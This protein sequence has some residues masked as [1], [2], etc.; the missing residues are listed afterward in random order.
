VRWSERKSGLYAVESDRTRR[1]DFRTLQEHNFV[2]DCVLSGGGG[3]GGGFA[4]VGSA[5]TVV[6]SG[7]PAFGQATVATHLL[8]AFI[9]SNGTVTVTGAGWTAAALQGGVSIYY[10]PNCSAGETAPTFTTGGSEIIAQLLEFSGG[11][12]SSPADQ[13]GTASTSSTQAPVCTGNDSATKELILYAAYWDSA[14]T[15]GTV[16]AI[17][18]TDGSGTAVTLSGSTGGAAYGVFSTNQYY[19]FCWGIAGSGAVTTPDTA[20]A[21]VTV[22]SGGGSAIASF[23]HA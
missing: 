4:L 13:S 10:K 12:T 21:S 18:M 11:L 6:E 3:G 17:S 2:D 15:G 14:N 5:G 19:C 9:N 1:A 23:K 22:F 8:A 7:T 16:D 20:S